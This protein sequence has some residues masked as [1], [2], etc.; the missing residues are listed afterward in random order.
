LYAGSSS[1]ANTD[2]PSR[3]TRLSAGVRSS[4]G[5]SPAPVH[6]SL[7]YLLEHGPALATAVVLAHARALV[8]LAHAEDA[9]GAGATLARADDGCVAATAAAAPIDCQWI[10]GARDQLLSCVRLALS[11][12]TGQLEEGVAAKESAAAVGITAV[13]A[14]VYGGALSAASSSLCEAADG[15]LAAA[16]RLEGHCQPV[17]GPH[18]SGRVYPPVGSVLIGRP[19]V[20]GV[21]A[22]VTVAGGVVAAASPGPGACTLRLA[23]AQAAAAGLV[24]LTGML[25]QDA[26]T[27]LCPRAFDLPANRQRDAAGAD[28][29]RV[30]RLRGGNGTGSRGGGALPPAAKGWAAEGAAG[31]LAVLQAFLAGTPGK[32]A[33][34]F[35]QALARLAVPPWAA[36]RW[37]GVA[38]GAEEVRSAA[39]TLAEALIAFARSQEGTEDEDGAE[40]DEHEVKRGGTMGGARD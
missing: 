19:G 3:R 31:A 20:A 8:R 7:A 9:A 40:M 4:T 38:C 2:G 24:Q 22:T 34:G 36:A 26:C 15:L 25:L 30:V 28:A 16:L 21:P 12:L 17:H 14:G 29:A 39:A 5:A 37:P 33:S 1:A 23:A 6:A 32:P 18:S 13:A 11:A 27:A 10:A 35:A